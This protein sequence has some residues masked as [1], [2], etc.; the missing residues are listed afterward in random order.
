MAGTDANTLISRVLGL[1]AQW[2]VVKSEMDV[3]QRQL[4]LELDFAAGTKF[5]CPRCG[6]LCAVHGTVDKEWRQLDFCQHRTDLQAR[7]T[8]AEHGVSQV[9]VR[10]ARAGSGF[11]LL[12]D[13]MILLLAQQMSVSAAARLRAKDHRLWRV[14]DQYVTA[15]HWDKDWSKV[16]RILFDETSDRRGRRYR[17]NV[18]DAESSNLDLSSISP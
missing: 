5:V 18:I 10:W 4:H 16:R 11:T 6:Q 15:A 3:P 1:S 13:G 8:C 9:E 12:M 17:T 2:S 14:I 7:V